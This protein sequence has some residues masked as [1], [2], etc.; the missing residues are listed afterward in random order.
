MDILQS[1]ILVKVCAE[2]FSETDIAEAQALLHRY[3][4]PSERLQKRKGEDMKSKTLFDILKWLHEA[5]DSDVPYFVCDN[6]NS[7]PSVDVHDIDVSLLMREISLMRYENGLIKDTCQAVVNECTTTME[8]FQ[9]LLYQ[10]SDRVQAVVSSTADKALKR[11]SEL[12]KSV[13]GTLKQQA[14]IVSSGNDNATVATAAARDEA[15]ASV[16]QPEDSAPVAIDESQTV[17]VNHV[18]GATGNDDDDYDKDNRTENSD[19]PPLEARPHSPAA[20]PYQQQVFPPASDTRVKACGTNENQ[21][22]GTRPRVAASRGATSRSGLRAAP[23]A[24]RVDMFVSRLDCD[25]TSIQLKE[26]LSSFNIDVF[27]IESLET[28]HHSYASFKITIPSNKFRLFR[29]DQVWPEGTYTRKFYGKRNAAPNNPWW[30]T[31]TM[32][33]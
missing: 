33:P 27:C 6:V 28:K 30:S 20:T 19:F 11:Q 29:S 14:D 7:L 13:N 32:S 10:L 1:D 16:P 2:T 17:T 23:G 4:K 21:V 15:A 8:K 25:T 9:G 18:A 5:D 31:A 26:H 24:S 22:V 3:V 12:L